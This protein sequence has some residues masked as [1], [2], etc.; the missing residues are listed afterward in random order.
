MKPQHIYTALLALLFFTTA[1]AQSDVVDVLVTSEDHTT[2]VAAV[3]AANL[4]TTLKEQDELTLLAPSNEAFDALP[5]G[6]VENLLQAENNEK[7][8]A[9]LN[10]HVILGEISAE[11]LREQIDNNSNEV[12]LK[13]L[14][15]ESIRAS[16]E[17]GNV[18]LSDTKGNKVMVTVSDLKGSNG[19]VH[20]ID[21]V[22]MP[23]K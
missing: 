9:L 22:L 3:K 13:T 17:N 7:L 15:G 4:V 11:K 2:L 21:G 23:Q 5:A 1:T 14:Q 10:Y 16:L 18:I 20:V 6:T 8:T 19:I 12:S